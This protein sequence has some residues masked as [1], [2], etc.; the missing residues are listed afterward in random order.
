MQESVVCMERCTGGT[1][2]KEQ[3]HDQKHFD[4][5][6]RETLHIRETKETCEELDTEVKRKEK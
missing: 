5:D 4:S 1:E 3:M 2:T 6:E